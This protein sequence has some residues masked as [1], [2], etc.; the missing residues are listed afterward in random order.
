M[1]YER[2]EN[3]NIDT[4]L[5]EISVE[6]KQ[7]SL[8]RKLPGV[9]HVL[10]LWDKAQPLADVPRTLL[11]QSIRTTLDQL[12]TEILAGDELLDEA[13]FADSQLLNLVSQQVSKSMEFSLKRVINATGVV[14]HTNL[15]RSLLPESAVKRL[16]EVSSRYSNLEFDLER[17]VRGSR[18]SCVE[19]IL[20]EISGAE[21]AMVVNNNAGAVFLSLDTLAK[22]REVIVSRGELVE[23][24]GSFRIP[25]VMAR[26]G[27]SLVEVGTTNRTHLPDYEGAIRD[28]TALLL[29][30]H[31][32]NF[33]M[34][35]FTAD[36][37]LDDLVA[38]GAKYH[39][40]VMK[41]LGSGNFV[42]LSK[43]GLM[44]ETTVQE[45]VATGVDVVTFSG[46]KMLGGPQAGIIVGRKDVVESIK[47]NPINRALRI[48][49][50]TL[51]AL[52]ATLHLYRD[53]A[54]AMSAIPTLRM[55]T[56]SPRVIA[57][58]ARRLRKRLNGLGNNRLEAVIIDSSSKVGGG[59]LPL[60]ELPTKCVGVMIER[61]SANAIERLMR[62]S[63]PPII[64]HIENDVFIM[65][66]RTVQ[67]EEIGIIASAFTRILTEG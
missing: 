3:R 19:D 65:D 57:N 28:E 32:S 23:I 11:V 55:L 54:E 21:A 27:A 61:L 14:V 41:D 62:S 36:V 34:L 63:A 31:T 10:D 6:P 42:D 26:S 16:V 7:Q 8:L 24:G 53:E 17:G 52:E 47:K 51:A 33:S 15:G 37:H 4:I 44:K 46:D 49:K 20:C 56:L 1:C 59:A 67:D 39:I 50:L 58:K 60:Q 12:R 13:V 43:Y 66:V 35:G 18:Y 5:R 29:K 2:K 48:D 25:D 38:L 9:D 30:V 40:P 45:T 22:G 64:G